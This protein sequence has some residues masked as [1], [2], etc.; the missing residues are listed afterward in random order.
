MTSQGPFGVPLFAL[1]EMIWAQL[2]S[3]FIA[4]ALLFVT[5]NIDLFIDT[6]K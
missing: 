1:V 2:L 6:K 3:A 5:I 4:S